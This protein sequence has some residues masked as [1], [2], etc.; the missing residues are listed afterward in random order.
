[1]AFSTR[2]AF[3][4]RNSPATSK[5]TRRWW[6]RSSASFLP[7]AMRRS[8][9]WNWPN[10]LAERGRGQPS[11]KR[12]RARACTKACARQLSERGA[13]RAESSV[14][15]HVKLF[16]LLRQ[17]HPGPNRSE[18]LAVELPDGAAVAD[19]IPALNL[20]AQLVRHAFIN[21]QQKTLDTQLAESDQV[22]LF[23]PVTG[24]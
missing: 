9:R 24:G 23:S 1:M 22:S 4:V 8:R 11:S 12:F 6:M 5:S 2:F 7:T 19:L 16:A 20:P 21:N 10:A 15:V 17:H 3:T 14:K 18:P 13:R